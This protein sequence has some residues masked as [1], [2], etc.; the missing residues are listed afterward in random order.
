MIDNWFR[1]CIGEICFLSTEDCEPL[2]GQIKKW[3]TVTTPSQSL[4]S[5]VIQSCKCQ[6][7]HN[8]LLLVNYTISRAKFCK[9][10]LNAKRAQIY[11]TPAS[12]SRFHWCELIL[13]SFSRKCF[14]SVMQV[15]FWFKQ[16]RTC[17]SQ[18]PLFWFQ[19]FHKILNLAA[20]I[21]F[22]SATRALV[23]TETDVG[24]KTWLVF[25]IPIHPEGVGRGWGQGSVRAS[26]VPPA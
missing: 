22:H 11:L 23:R 8:C 16:I 1:Q 4:R 6:H 24:D 12:K 26:E 10:E 21:C 19:A 18:P 15:F 25:D 13:Q 9:A 17:N 2:I 7:C 3:L 5:A 20:R 14:L